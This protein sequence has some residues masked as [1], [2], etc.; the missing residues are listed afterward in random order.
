MET[1][2]TW[3]REWLENYMVEHTCETCHGARLNDDVLSVKL[4]GKN[5]YEV[6]QMS[7]KEL[8][9][10]FD[11]LKLSEEKKEIAKLVIKEVQDRLHF[12]RMWD[13]NI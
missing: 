12:L 8:I 13:L 10:F 1:S 2:S 6:T 3:V 7:I 9:P 5:I 11:N 4:N